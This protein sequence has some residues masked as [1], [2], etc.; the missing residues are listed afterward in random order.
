MAPDADR[1]FR[2][3][4][5]PPGRRLIVAVSGG[6]DSLSLLFLARDF[7]ARYAPATAMQAVTVDHGLRAGSADEARQVAELCAAHGI[8]HRTL[9]WTG[10][11][12]ATGTLNA[13]RDARYALLAQAA[14]DFGADCVLT[15]HTLDDQA[16]TVAMRA[17]RGLGAGLS[18]MA[19]ATLFDGRVW[20]VRP[21][22]E[23]RR[24][25][26]RDDLR[27]RGVGWLDDPSNDNP[28]YERVRT[29]ARLAGEDAVAAL[30]RQAWQAGE[31]RRKL[32]AAAAL[33]LERHLAMPS[34]GLFRLDR[35]FFRE[36]GEASV[37]GLRA[38]LAT[39]GGAP[40]LPDAT[41]TQAVLRLVADDGKPTR[42]P[43]SRAVVDA[44][45]DAV[46]IRREA[47]GVPEADIGEAGCVW[48][49]RWRFCPQAG[50]SGLRV[51]PLGQARAAEFAPEIPG[52]PKS[53]VRAA[54][55]QEPSFHDG[56]DVVGSAHPDGNLPAGVAAR[57]IAAPYARFLP[58]FDLPL[59]AV[60]SRIV[61]GA[62]LPQSPWKHHNG[63][64]A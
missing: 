25:R 38:V 6:S 40:Y 42:V 56:G 28:R 12:P 54:L 34:P 16:E 39:A 41:R 17:E 60:L 13:A 58:D 18:G 30:G 19:S 10:P 23:Q 11:K 4:L 9:V 46:W 36:E 31:A 52:V 57:R 22:L 2:G 14:A 26:L 35:A 63:T 1:A 27:R 48:D 15:G 8:P 24:E 29:R 21:L 55:C 51:A 45:R 37:L 64:G 32:A 62:P 49:G 50:R 3:L 7:L 53:L 59:A 44:R 20:I 5:L 61:G 33:L 47:R 43:L